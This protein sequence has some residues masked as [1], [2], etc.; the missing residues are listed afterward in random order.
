MAFTKKIALHD[1]IKLD[2][3]DFS[4]DFRTFGL[5][6]EASD[7]DVSGFSATGTDETLSGPKAQGFEGEAF[8]TEEAAAILWALHSNATIFQ[9]QWTPGGLLTTSGNKT[10]YAQCQLRTFNPN[11]TRGDVQVMT[12][13]FKTADATGI[14]QATGT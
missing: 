6:S 3:T 5:S 12:C 10:Y 9:V 11:D 8:Y 4:N 13:T 7:V 1:E 2:G 14:T